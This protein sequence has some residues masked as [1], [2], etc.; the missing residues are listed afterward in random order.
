ME[1]MKWKR[2]KEWTKKEWKVEE[3]KVE[4]G[5]ERMEEWMEWTE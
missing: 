1:G 2:R 3:G 5:P 4:N